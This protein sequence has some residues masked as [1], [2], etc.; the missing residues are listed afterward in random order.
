MFAIDQGG[1]YHH[2]LI[3]LIHEQVCGCGKLEL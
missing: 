2:F 1:F 3:S